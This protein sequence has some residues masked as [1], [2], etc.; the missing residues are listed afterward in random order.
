MGPRQRPRQQ[1]VEL[2]ARAAVQA[3]HA[4]AYHAAAA[5]DPGAVKGEEARQAA[6]DAAAMQLI[7]LAGCGEAFVFGRGDPGTTLARFDDA[8]EPVVQMRVAHTHPEKFFAPPPIMPA[9]LKSMMDGL[10]EKLGN[11]DPET[12]KIQPP[13]QAQALTGLYLGL[14]HIERDGLPNAA[15][16]R[17]RDLHYAG[18][19]HEIQFCRLAKETGFLTAG[20]LRIRA[21]S[22]STAAS[23]TPM[24]LRINFMR[25]AAAPIKAFYL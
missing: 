14:D 10:K 15:A 13:D 9:R 11:L 2:L 8:L 7:E 12:L 24:T 19:Y 17:A 25:C 1:I 23:S 18:Y 16:L 4:E 3:E 5:A 21:V 20:I 6:C 22:T